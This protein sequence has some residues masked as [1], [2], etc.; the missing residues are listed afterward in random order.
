LQPTQ[1]KH[2]KKDQHKG[3]DAGALGLEQD[4]FFGDEPE[5]FDDQAQKQ[6]QRYQYKIRYQQTPPFRFVLRKQA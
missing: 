4:L 2:K 1:C 3:V 6:R 5:L